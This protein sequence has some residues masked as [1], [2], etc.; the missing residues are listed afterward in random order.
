MKS[1]ENKIQSGWFNE[2]SWKLEG[3]DEAVQV[4]DSYTLRK[5]VDE[6]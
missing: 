5:C 2:A 6:E 1:N 4:A 3:I